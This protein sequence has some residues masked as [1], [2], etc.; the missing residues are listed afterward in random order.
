M[1]H[2]R[3]FSILCSLLIVCVPYAGARA[4]CKTDTTTAPSGSLFHGIAALHLDAGA[5]SAPISGQAG[6]YSEGK[7]GIAICRWPAWTLA[8]VGS[9]NV[10]PWPTSYVAKEAATLH[11]NLFVTTSGFE[12]ERRWR[13][14][15]IVHP[16][17]VAGAGTLE[18]NYRY[19]YRDQGIV[20]YPREGVSSATY[21]MAALGLE[22]SLFK[23]M[24]T[25]AL[26]GSRI[27]GDVTT[28]GLND[29][30]FSGQYVAFGFGFGKFR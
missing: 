5:V 11:P 12:L 4:D 22:V 7:L 19:V 15:K 10:E 28:P 6:G 13:I 14:A 29:A 18:S 1:P 16:M 8:V 3:R 9:S 30:P 2:G 17:I 24:T 27:V 26:L 21:G 23:Y 25:Y 20:G